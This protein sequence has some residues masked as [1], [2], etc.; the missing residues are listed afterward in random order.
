ML[1]SKM[2]VQSPPTTYP[3]MPTNRW[4]PMSSEFSAL[5]FIYN[6]T[7]LHLETIKRYLTYLSKVYAIQIIV[8]S[9]LYL[10]TKK[11]VTV[12]AFYY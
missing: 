3:Q 9:C 6:Y 1:Q 7:E 12:L 10:Q 4:S 11:L 5:F 2:F 8:T